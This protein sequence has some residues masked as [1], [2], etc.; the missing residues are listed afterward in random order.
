MERKPWTEDEES[1][2]EYFLLT[3]FE[4]PYDEIEKFLGRS[5]I[6]VQGKIAKMR[7]KDKKLEPRAKPWREK[8]DQFL[9]NN[10]QIKTYYEIGYALNR[11]FS[12]VE[13][14]MR[15]L[16]IRKAKNLMSKKDEIQR[17][18]DEGFNQNEIAKKLGFSRKAI[19]NFCNQNGIKIN[20]ESTKNR[21]FSI[22]GRQW[23]ERKK[24][25]A[26]CNRSN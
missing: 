2:L 13:N 11:S 18:S 1:Y 12:S 25:Y 15:K 16:G 19:W 7:K 3:D 9:L 23:A 24:Q 6:S 17:L 22:Q 5:K 10:Y 21:V 4:T 26:A 14:R 20:Y 8:E